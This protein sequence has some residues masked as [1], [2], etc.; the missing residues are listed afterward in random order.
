MWRLF[1]FIFICPTYTLA[2]EIIPRFSS[3]KMETNS[4]TRQLIQENV[5]TTNFKTGFSY[6]VQGSGITLKDPNVSLSPQAQLDHTQTVDT[7]R[8]SW[9]SPKL[10]TKPEWVQVKPA[11]GEAFSLTEH[12]EGP[13]LS[14]I[15]TSIRTID[16]E[17]T[18]SSL[19]IFGN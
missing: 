18:S 14:A 12:F 11:S 13:G 7:V 8:Y 15:S 10:E 17:I 19:S 6:S 1:I 5:V 16:T 9:I 2:G 3:G 4:I